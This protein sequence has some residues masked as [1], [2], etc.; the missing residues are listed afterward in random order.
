M[1]AE[2][3]EGMGTQSG[4]WSCRR[5]RRKKITAG[6]NV[7]V[8]GGRIFEGKG[9]R[10]RKGEVDKEGKRGGHVGKERR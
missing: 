3:R 9:G 1:R 6:R 4:E 2:G 8:N 5:K 7:D 10:W